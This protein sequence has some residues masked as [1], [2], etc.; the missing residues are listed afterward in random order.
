M[1]NLTFFSF[2]CSEESR[3]FLEKN[4]PLRF[5]LDNAHDLFSWLL[6]HS[7]SFEKKQC[8]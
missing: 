1:S 5:A 4:F 3:D 2:V 7:N 6:I 8:S